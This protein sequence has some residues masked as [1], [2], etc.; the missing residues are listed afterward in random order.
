M[1][2]STLLCCAMCVCVCGCVIECLC[3]THV[4]VCVMCVFVQ[5]LT[6]ALVA[7]VSL[8]F[9]MTELNTTQHN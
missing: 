5:H 4:C 6:A 2:Y 3:A 7:C 8:T 9:T 1:V